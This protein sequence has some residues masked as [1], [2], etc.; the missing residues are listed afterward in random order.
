LQWCTLRALNPFEDVNEF[1]SESSPSVLGGSR[2]AAICYLNRNF[3]CTRNRYQCMWLR[4]ALAIQKLVD[5][6]PV[7]I[8][9]TRAIGLGP[10]AFVNL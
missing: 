1:I 10:P 6:G 3:E 5:D 7:Q 9:R 4:L 8:S 2:P